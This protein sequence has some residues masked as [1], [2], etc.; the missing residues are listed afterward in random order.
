MHHLHPHR[1]LTT[2]ALLLAPTAALAE[3]SAQLTGQWLVGESEIY[4]DIVD[5]GAETVTFEVQG[6]VTVATPS[7]EIVGSFADGD[8]FAPTENGPHRLVF[9]QD[10]RLD[11]DVSVSGAEGE[12]RLWSR[13]WVLDGRDYDPA[14]G[15]DASFFALVDAGVEGSTNVVEMQLRGWS[16]YRWHAIAT[17]TGVDNT[18][19]RSTPNYQARYR[20]N[21]PLYLHPPAVATHG[22]VA[23]PTAD[24][25]RFSFN[26]DD[27]QGGTFRFNVGQPG[28]WHIV[29]DADD[30]GVADPTSNADLAFVGWAAEAGDRYL[31]WDGYDRDGDLVIK[32]T[33]CE[34]TAA[35]GEVHF[36]SDDIET[37]YPGMRVYGV[38][39]GG[40]RAPMTMYW[41]D[42]DVNDFDVEMPDGQMP[43]A[44]SGPDGVRSSDAEDEPTANDGARSWGNFMDE[45]KGDEAVL[46]TWTRLAIT[47]PDRIDMDYDL[48]HNQ[49]EPEMEV[50]VDTGG[51]AALPDGFRGGYY[52]GGCSTPAGVAAPLVSLIIGAFAAGLRR[53]EED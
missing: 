11:W 23:E 43:A 47:P 3:G 12:G 34:L 38:D 8:T 14:K 53:R 52:L 20:P 21:I 29:C 42:G 49:P 24:S 35:I 2:V 36:L 16:G 18:E 17:P 10:Q 22:D 50:F 9:S 1:A 25:L 32:L 45:G 13:D 44:T 39:A 46:D 19:L 5:H 27:G 37:A 30:D 41:N 4:L 33:A 51:L 28:T 48:G 6:R 7:G 15:V 31:T 40:D 26:E